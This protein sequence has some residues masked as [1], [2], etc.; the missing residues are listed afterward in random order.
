MAGSSAQKPSKKKKTAENQLNSETSNFNDNNSF[1]AGEDRNKRK[2]DD[3]LTELQL[4]QQKFD[5]DLFELKD[6]YEESI[7]R[8]EALEE[9]VEGLKDKLKQEEYKTSILMAKNNDLEQ[10]SRRN[11]IRVF[12]IDDS[13][14]ET[15][16]KSEK[17]VTDLLRQKLSVDLAP[18]QIQ[19]AHRAGKFNPGANRSI[20]MQLVNRKD[21]QNIMQ[22]RRKLKGSGFTIAEDLTPINVRRLSDLKKLDVVE[23]SWS[24]QGKLFVQ[25]TGRPDI[26]REIPS[27]M[28]INENIFD[29]KRPRGPLQQPLQQIAGTSASASSATTSETATNASIVVT[30]TT[31]AASV[32]GQ[33]TSLQT[34]A[35]SSRPV[36]SSQQAAS[37]LG[38]VTSSNTTTTSSGP[39]TSSL[40]TS[41]ASGPVTSSQATKS[42]KAPAKQPSVTPA[43]D[44]SDKNRQRHNKSPPTDMDTSEIR[45]KPTPKDT[46]TPKTHIQLRLEDL[47]QLN[48]TIAFLENKQPH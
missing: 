25:K 1:V 15:A 2:M 14:R 42:S 32:A 26:V 27:D 33:V 24:S 47:A 19:V 7:K 35:S 45:D 20:I 34:S 39:V 38:S 18:S 12:G 43:S 44:S 40:K 30:T 22:V 41:L 9:S 16:E 8:I 6:R 31:T 23:N 29:H 5:Y 11:N 28:P 17:H 46:S 4:N 48:Q 21:K 10:Y 3:T 36:T 37:S 13:D